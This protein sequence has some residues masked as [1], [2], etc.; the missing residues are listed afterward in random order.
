MI[1][2]GWFSRVSVCRCPCFWPIP[3]SGLGCFGG[4][5]LCLERKK[6]TT[7][8]SPSWRHVIYNYPVSVALVFTP[9]YLGLAAAWLGNEHGCYMVQFSKH[10]WVIVGRRLDSFRIRRIRSMEISS[11]SWLEILIYLARIKPCVLSCQ[12]HLLEAFGSF[13]KQGLGPMLKQ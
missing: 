7:G 1:F 8:K 9:R 11:F 13:L 6:T 10:P 2:S 5:K 4:K 12:A 3:T